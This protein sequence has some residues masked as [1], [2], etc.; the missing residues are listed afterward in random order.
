M[1]NSGDRPFFKYLA[2]S[3]AVI[4]M[5]VLQSTPKLLPEFWGGKP[6][7]LLALALAIASFEEFIP[8][9]IYAAVCGLFA[10]LNSGGTVGYFAISFTVVCAAIRYLAGMYLNATLFTFMITSA[11]AIAAVLGIYFLMFRLAVCAED[12]G[13]L[14]VSHYLPRMGTTLLCAV[15]LYFLIW[16]LHSA[17]TAKQ[18]FLR[19]LRDK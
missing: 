18:G 7:L 2:Y 1:K 8:T 14:F 11:A 6:F 10:D 19:D 9:V 17:F 4:L 5:G 3:L 12:A 13:T 16:F 15:P